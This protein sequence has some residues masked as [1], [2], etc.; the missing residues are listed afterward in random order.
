MTKKYLSYPFSNTN[1]PSYGN[2]NASIKLQQDKC[3]DSGDSCN[4]YSFTLSNHW[5]TH[6]DCPSHFFQN[7][8]TI[9]D[10]PPENWFFKSPFC[11]DI[12]TE[13]AKIINE[14]DIPKLPENCD[15]LIL[16]THFCYRR[17]EEIYSTHNPGLA[18]ELGLF[19]RKNYPNLK[20]V[21]F[22]FISLSSFQNRNLGREAHKTFL[23]P[24]GIN[25]PLFIFEDMDLRMDLTQL[26]SLQTVPLLVEGIDSAPVTIIAKFND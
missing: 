9:L 3:M 4:V 13:P 23:D 22:D 19:L 20:A 11:I 8:K 17:S 25:D 10:Y 7:A 1:Q 15:F 6:V 5:G 12:P 24:N 26:V 16:K 2:P 18:P 21:G 14:K